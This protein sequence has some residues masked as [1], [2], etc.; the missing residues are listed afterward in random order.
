MSTVILRSL[1]TLTCSMHCVLGWQIWRKK[2][3]LSH[4]GS[5]GHN[6]TKVFIIPWHSQHVKGP[7]ALHH[8]IGSSIMDSISSALFLILAILFLPGVS[9]LLIFFGGLP[10]FLVGRIAMLLSLVVIIPISVYIRKPHVR[11]TLARELRG[12]LQWHS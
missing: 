2:R 6:G 1:V 8:A 12:F 4:L 5:G 3:T 7:N 10:Q 9:V 11:T